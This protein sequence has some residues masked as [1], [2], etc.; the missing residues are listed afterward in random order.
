LASQAQAWEQYRFN[1]LEFKYYT[2]TGSQTP[3]SIM[4][5]PD[6]DA[7]DASPGSEQIASTYEDVTEDAPWKDQCCT[8]RPRAMHPMGPKKF[9]RNGPLA[10][11]LDIKTYDAGNLFVGT[12]DGTA[13]AWGKL[14]VEYD[15]SL[16]T[17]QLPPTGVLVASQHIT[18][19]TPTTTQLLSALP[20]N[21]AGSSA[22]A[23]TA[24]NVVTFLAAGDYLIEYLA[25]GTTIT[26]TGAPAVSASGSFI[27]TFGLA[28]TGL[29]VV[30]SGGAEIS[31]SVA[32][33]AV[34]GTTVTF[35]NTVVAGLLS[36]MIISQLPPN[37]V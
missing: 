35:N 22:I 5:I 29:S 27:T 9:V 3:G 23:N 26:Q 37:L 32:L 24:L 33:R 34:V 7:A 6:Y 14:W 2:R 19:A 25:T 13:I 20:V 15:V 31:Q 12:T 17:P 18:G 11:N 21:S 1:K 30:G 28:G 4:L 8:L 10:A 16:Y 36:E